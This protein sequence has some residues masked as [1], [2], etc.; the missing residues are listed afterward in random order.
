MYI[1]TAVFRLDWDLWICFLLQIIVC[2]DVYFLSYIHCVY[3]CVNLFSV[4]TSVAHA[5]H[6]SLTIIMHCISV[7]TEKYPRFWFKIIA[8]INYIT[9]CCV[10]HSVICFVVSLWNFSAFTCLLAYLSWR[11]YNAFK[12]IKTYPFFV[13]VFATPTIQ[14]TKITAILDWNDNR[15]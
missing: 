11:N 7:C 14:W 2:G 1:L 12:N 6:A 8:I 4:P 10:H 13:S 15:I 3:L 9:A 5:S